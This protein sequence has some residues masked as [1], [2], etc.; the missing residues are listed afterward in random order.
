VAGSGVFV[1]ENALLLREDSV[2][3]GWYESDD[4]DR[5]TKG[6]KDEEASRIRIRVAGWCH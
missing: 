5:T 6:A 2:I 4:K 1:Q 3:T